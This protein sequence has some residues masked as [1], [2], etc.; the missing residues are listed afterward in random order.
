M[1]R[2][3]PDQLDRDA[4]ETTGEGRTQP[5]E[6]SIC[7]LQEFMG[8]LLT[9]V[10]GYQKAL[11]L[12]G[13]RIGGRDILVR[14]LVALIGSKNMISLSPADLADRRCTR[15]L[16]GRSAALIPDVYLA[17]SDSRTIR[18]VDTLR[19]LIGEQ[20]FWFPGREGSAL[21]GDLLGVRFVITADRMTDLIDRA[22]R[23]R[24]WLVMLDT[25]QSDW[26][27]DAYDL[28]QS[29]IEELPEIANWAVQGYLRLRARGR[30]LPTGADRL[31][32]LVVGPSASL[33][34]D[35]VRACCLLKE[36]L[37]TVPQDL[38]DAF[39]L[40]YRQ[41]RLPEDQKP[42]RI[43]FYSRFERLFPQCARIR[44]RT[45]P[46]ANPV[47]RFA[48]ITLRAPASAPCPSDPVPPQEL[49]RIHQWPEISHTDATA[50]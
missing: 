25:S 27:H 18:V 3:C 1:F 50:K 48:N 41:A 34:Q 7:A 2:T 32:E 29:L 20:A 26:V 15:M 24:D 49:Q 38:F 42:G 47:Y 35:F 21:H 4:Q 39:C 5:D 11:A 30:F 22:G 28:Q 10:M 37:R 9:P 46:D 16:L 13:P 19:A 14:I 12:V 40:W 17:G 6:G 44:L 36:G 23:L 8:L 33:I 45:I 31:A 43:C